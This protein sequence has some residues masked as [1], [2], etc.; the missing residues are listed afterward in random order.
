MAKSK[1]NAVV[2]DAE[3]HNRNVVANGMDAVSKMLDEEKSL[4]SS[5]QEDPMVPAITAQDVA[6]EQRM[7]AVTNA[8]SDVLG[9]S[10]VTTLTNPEPV[11]SNGGKFNLSFAIKSALEQDVNM[12]RDDVLTHIEDTYGKTLTTD[13]GDG[14]FTNTLSVMRKKLKTQD[15]AIVKDEAGIDPVTVLKLCQLLKM[16]PQQLAQVIVTMRPVGSVDAI[17]IGLT[18][19][20]ELQELLNAQ[21]KTVQ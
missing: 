4:T 10:E 5:T 2:V 11:Q 12:T 9:G 20:N 13:F 15:Q 17:L 14:T 3:T 1:K 18:K 8:I 21:S 7:A 16:N 6:M 19:L